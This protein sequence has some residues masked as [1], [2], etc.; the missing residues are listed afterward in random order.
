MNMEKYKWYILGYVFY[1]SIVLASIW[2]ER[3]DFWPLLIIWCITIPVAFFIIWALVTKYRKTTKS[4]VVIST[5]VV[6]YPFKNNDDSI[7]SDSDSDFVKSWSLVD[8]AK[9]HGKMQI[10]EFT[11]GVTGKSF[12]S[13]IFTGKDDST[14]YVSFYS[15]LGVLTPQ[16]IKE[17]KDS[18]KVGLLKTNKYVLY[19]VWEGWDE[20]Y[21][22]I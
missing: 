6:D 8:F 7:N 2:N 11:N 10:G 12:K 1:A 20:V 15:K 3:R 5:A 9:E 22:G 4:N 16:Q 21:L 19:E 18:L 13:C 17:K 14:L